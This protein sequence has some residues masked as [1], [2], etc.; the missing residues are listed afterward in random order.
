MPPEGTSSAK[1]TWRRRLL[2]AR[3]AVPPEQR[4]AEAERITAV[5]S[6][7]ARDRAGTTVAAHVPFG[8]EPGSLHLVDA[9]REGGCRVL[10]PVVVEPD[11]PMRWA[12]YG[13]E[14]MLRPGNLGVL[15][16]SGP[17]LAPEALSEATA[18]LVPALGVDRAGVR[19][20]RGGGCYDR[21][22]PLAA[23][24]ALTAAVVRD[25][26][27][28]DQLPHGPHD[29]LLTSVITPGRGLLHLPR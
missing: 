15:E 19:L 10:L 23:P 5:I 27:L 3:R 6:E 18:I 13:G 7:V 8:T 14:A 29:A 1:R 22:L 12:E 24:S 21:S 17:L 25:A 26:E 16:P 2:A 4:R 11:G 20:G 28:V 9:L